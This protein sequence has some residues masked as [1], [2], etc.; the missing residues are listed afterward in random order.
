[1]KITIENNELVIRAPL[2]DA[3]LSST[4]KSYIIAS[5]SGFLRTE[6]LV[7]ERPVS[8]S[9]NVII[10]K[11]KPSAVAAQQKSRLEALD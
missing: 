8:V 3:V 4:G 1:M 9:L 6:L 2:G 5:T 11:E 7:K 10:P